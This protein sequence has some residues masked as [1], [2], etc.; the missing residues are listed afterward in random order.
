MKRCSLLILVLAFFSAPLCAQW[1]KVP[2]AR[3]PRTADGKLDLS[4]VW[5]PAANKWIRNLAADSK[6]E[7]IPFQAW[8]KTLY[9][10]RAAGLH[11][12]E[13]PDANC[14]PQGVPKILVAPAPWRVIQEPNY[15]V[16]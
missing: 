16:F 13:E 8:A 12:R 5:E 11:W 7:D 3:I 9:D 1:T 14:L 10:E 6:P 4:G 2:P 15:V